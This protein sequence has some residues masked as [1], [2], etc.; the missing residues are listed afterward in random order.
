MLTDQDIDKL[1]QIFATKE[2]LN[3]FATKDDLNRFATK[4]DLANM[5][6]RF[7][8]RFATKNDLIKME[9]RFDHKF[10][11][12]D[13]LQRSIDELIDMITDRFNTVLEKLDD[14]SSEIKGTRIVSG[15]HEGRLQKLEHKV[16]S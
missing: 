11:T 8:Q 16:F 9:E 6:N 3:R 12:K 14:I 15:N 4:D 2:D 10:A 5:E 13:H 1:K 7:G